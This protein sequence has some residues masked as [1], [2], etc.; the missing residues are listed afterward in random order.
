MRAVAEHPYVEQALYYLRKIDPGVDVKVPYVG[1]YEP[2]PD[3]VWCPACSAFG[4]LD[5][6]DARGTLIKHHGR[7][8]PCRLKELLP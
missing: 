7:D 2:L 1:P 5:R 8:W 3:R 4:V 6:H